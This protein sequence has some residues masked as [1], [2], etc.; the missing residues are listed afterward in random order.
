M[1]YFE[2]KKLREIIDFLVEIDKLA[3]KSC[4]HITRIV[5]QY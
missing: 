1:I 4:D 5:Y 3:A 2:K